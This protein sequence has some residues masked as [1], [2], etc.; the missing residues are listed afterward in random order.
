MYRRYMNTIQFTSFILNNMPSFSLTVLS[1]FSSSLH[2]LIFKK[3]LSSSFIPTF[4]SHFLLST[5]PPLPLSC[6]LLVFFIFYFSLHSI[7]YTVDLH[8]SP[9]LSIFYLPILH[10]IP[11]LPHDLYSFPSIFRSPFSP[12][13]SHSI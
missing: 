12:F 9:S 7:S 5:G 13:L 6:L 1:V 8:S 10:L 2:L 4:S 3:L 11:F